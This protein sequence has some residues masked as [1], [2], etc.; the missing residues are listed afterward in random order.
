MARPTI[1]SEDMEERARE[2]LVGGWRDEGHAIPSIV[3]MSSY[4][5]VSRATL[6]NW[7]S[8]KRGE[9]LDILDQ[10]NDDQHLALMNGGLLNTLNSNITKLAL[11]KHGYH[12]KQDT[13]VEGSL[14][15]SDMTDDQ[16]DAKL[17]ALVSAATE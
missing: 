11:G 4:L 9:F 10:C 1:W 13:K 15:L 2:Y 3:G 16:L 17:K 6:H 7:G 5:G 12:D 8:Q 14:S